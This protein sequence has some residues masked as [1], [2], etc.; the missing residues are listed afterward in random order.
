VSA[1]YLILAWLRRYWKMVAGSGAVITAIAIW[2]QRALSCAKGWFQI[3]KARW[4][5]REAEEKYLKAKQERLALERAG[6]LTERKLT[7]QQRAVIIQTIRDQVRDDGPG[8][9][10]LIWVRSFPVADCANYTFELV[11]VLREAGIHAVSGS[12]AGLPEFSDNDLFQTGIWIRG[13]DR[14]YEPP[15]ERVIL[16]ALKRAGVEVKHVPSETYTLTL[17]VGRE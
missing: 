12:T 13:R 1:L 15:T 9:S 5:S 7:R 6:R 8:T 3:A 16:E 17:V 4:E 11:G 10:R 14:N 2:G